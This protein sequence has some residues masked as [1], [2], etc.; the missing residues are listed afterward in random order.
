MQVNA[1]HPQ[2]AQYYMV[3][4]SKACEEKKKKSVEL[5][6]EFSRTVA[7]DTAER[8]K[9]GKSGLHTIARDQEV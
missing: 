9:G 8:P 4:R 7:V 2:S 5:S 3:L 1:F 6:T